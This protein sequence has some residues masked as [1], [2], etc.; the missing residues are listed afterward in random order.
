MPVEQVGYLVTE[1]ALQINLPQPLLQSP[2][3]VRH[4][5]YNLC[6]EA[7]IRR[8]L[9]VPSLHELPQYDRQQCVELQIDIIPA[10]QRWQQL[11][12][13]R[14]GTSALVARLLRA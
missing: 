6:H 1:Q 9:A 7:L 14:R 8:D 3:A 4:D 5:L 11:I 13:R 10:R 12:D 2:R